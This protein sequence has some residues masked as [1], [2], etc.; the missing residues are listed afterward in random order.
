MSVS[1]SSFH[2]YL[3]IWS[4]FFKQ[5]TEAELLKETTWKHR[6]SASS[7]VTGSTLLVNLS[8]YCHSLDL[9][10]DSLLAFHW[11]LPLCSL[12]ARLETKTRLHRLTKSDNGLT[13]CASQARWEHDSLCGYSLFWAD[14][15]NMSLLSGALLSLSTSLTQTFFFS[16]EEIRHV[17]MWEKCSL[18]RCYEIQ[19]DKTKQLH[20][21]LC[22]ARDNKK[23]I[24]LLNLKK[25]GI[26]KTSLK[27][28]NY[29]C[30]SST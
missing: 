15:K 28:N 29:I 26:K 3:H 17:K 14:R 12:G 7:K 21:T 30:K 27:E 22:D 5:A 18:H 1:V 23:E 8:L 10:E 9:G 13:R 20:K 6:P 2:L 11:P 25:E 4:H 16:K 24:M 19:N